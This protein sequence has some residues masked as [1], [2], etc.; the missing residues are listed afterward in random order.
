LNCPALS[1]I[2]WSMFT[3]P[4]L[5]PGVRLLVTPAYLTNSRDR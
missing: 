3:K 4:L 1:F 5:R 2:R